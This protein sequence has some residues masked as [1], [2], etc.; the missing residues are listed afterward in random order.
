MIRLTDDWIKELISKQNKN[1]DEIIYWLKQ[2]D[3][4]KIEKE[5]C[6]LTIIIDK[7]EIFFDFGITNNTICSIFD[8]KYNTTK[9]FNNLHDIK[10]YILKNKIFQKFLRSKK[11]KRII[12]NK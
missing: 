12:F 2:F 4:I 3:F 9:K 5:D 10:Y 7:Y 11:L 1:R 6:L 8:E